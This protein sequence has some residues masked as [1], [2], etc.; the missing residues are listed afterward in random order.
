MQEPAESPSLCVNQA[1]S[2]V[3]GQVH[4]T[5]PVNSP[6]SSVAAGA[7]AVNAST[8]VASPLAPSCQQVLYSVH[9]QIPSL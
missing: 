8:G 4:S 9:S 2:Y 7:H 6:A 5:N 1:V 3:D